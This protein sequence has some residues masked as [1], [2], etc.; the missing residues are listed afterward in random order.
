MTPHPTHRRTRRR[1]GPLALV[2]ALA[3]CHH[4]RP[5]AGAPVVSEP[6]G[7]SARMLAR[8]VRLDPAKARA[9]FELST[10]AYLTALSV[11]PGRGITLIWTTVD[12]WVAGTHTAPVPTATAPDATQTAQAA[13]AACM[14]QQSMRAP[15]TRRVRRNVQ[16]DEKSRPV[17]GGPDYVEIEVDRRG[18]A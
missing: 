6:I 5:P 13:Y 11:H 7:E 14:Q 18:L 16:R 9:T 8:I 1:A 2:A 12:P 4:A 3:A 10:P 17:D 15:A